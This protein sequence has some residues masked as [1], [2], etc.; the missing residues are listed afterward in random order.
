MSVRSTSSPRSLLSM[1]IPVDIND[2]K[3]IMRTIGL[4]SQYEDT[5][6][7][8][9]GGG[10][11]GAGDGAGDG[12]DDG[13]DDGGGDDSDDDDDDDGDDQ[14]SPPL[15]SQRT[16]FQRVTGSGRVRKQKQSQ[17]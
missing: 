2:I 13:D 15:V 8:G 14:P 3:C 6:G 9:G 1:A 16:S 7:G 12:S 17:C 5:C 11:D 4:Q 10:G